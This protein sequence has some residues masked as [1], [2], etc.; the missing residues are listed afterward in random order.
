MRPQAIGGLVVALAA[1]AVG[2]GWLLGAMSL[3]ARRAST[4]STYRS[5]GGPVYTAVQ[6]GCSAVLILIGLGLLVVV[7]FVRR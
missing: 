6:V 3:R 1:I 5:L 4:S 2:V 7:F